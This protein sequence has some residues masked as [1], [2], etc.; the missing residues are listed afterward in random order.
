MEKRR[1]RL[2]FIVSSI[3]L[4]PWTLLLRQLRLGYQGKNKKYA[5]FILFFTIA[6]FFYGSPPLSLA[7]EVI[8]K[9]NIINNSLFDIQIT[10]PDDFK[11]LSPGNELLTSV[12]LVNLG[13]AGRI[14]VFLDYWIVDADQSII[15]KNRETVAVETQT[16]FVR[17]F[18]IP[19]N[20]KPGIYSLNAK[21]TYADGKEA[22]AHSSFEIITKQ[23]DKRLYYALI[24]F[25]G[26][27][28]LI[29]AVFKSKPLVEK[30]R[31]R[32]EVSRIVRNRQL[33]R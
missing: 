31:I 26:L 7:Q 6:L 21:L 20:V 1:L 18:D 10:I 33:T 25:I 30:L 32:H 11:I 8:S 3:C 27:V 22:T 4:Y 14:D 15:L 16:S 5:Q 12:K 9:T 28:I 23:T 19:K 13:S 17:T 24:G 2:L 29:Y